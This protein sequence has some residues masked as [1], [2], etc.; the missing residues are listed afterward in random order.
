MARKVGFMEKIGM[1]QVV[2]CLLENHVF[3]A[4]RR[5]GAG[6]EVTLRALWNSQEPCALW[7]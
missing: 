2:S 1:V 3:H 5:D 4:T 6:I 7:T